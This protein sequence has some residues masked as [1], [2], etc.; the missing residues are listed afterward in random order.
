M[1]IASGRTD[2]DVVTAWLAA[3]CDTTR[4][5]DDFLES[6]DEFMNLDVKLATAILALFK[7]DKVHVTETSQRMFLLIDEQMGATGKVARGRQVLDI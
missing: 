2:D 1:V 4:S 5:W 7:D 6:G 3:A